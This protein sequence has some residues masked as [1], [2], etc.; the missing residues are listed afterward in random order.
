MTLNPSHPTANPP[1]PGNFCRFCHFNPG[2]IPLAIA[3]L[4]AT[5]FTASAQDTL[6]AGFANP[7]PEARSRAYW[8]WLNGNVTKAAITRDLEE[9]KAKGFGGAIIT[10]AGGAEQ[11]GNAQ[12]PA[13]PAFFSPEWRELFKFTLQEANRLGL[14]MSL[15]IQSGWNLGGPMIR[16]EDAPKKLA[17][18]ETRVH[19][20]LLFTN[21]LAEPKHAP[22]LYRDVC[23]L[24]FPVTPSA[25]PHPP[26]QNYSE[27]ALI[28]GLGW[29]TP[30]CAP[31]LKELPARPGEEDT[32]STNVL[33]ITA[34]M[35]AG[36]VLRWDAPAG[37]WLVLRLGYTLNDHSRV[38]TSSQTWQ[39]YALDPIDGDIFR[40]YW[41]QVVEPLIADAGPLAGNTFKYLHTDSWE[42]EVLNWTPS[43]RAEF[44]RRRGYD[45]L[46]FLPVLA[47][48]IVDSREASD[49]FLWDF[50]RTIGDLAIDNHFKLF[51]EG[52]HRHG[53]EIHPE[54][55]GPHSVP[56]DSLQCLGMDD[57]PMSEFWARSPIHRIAESDRFFI[58]QPAS[59][60]HTYGR[61][62]VVGEGFTDIGLHWQET[63]WDNL[64]PTFDRA[65]CE[66]LNRLVWHA[67][68]CSPAAM[69]L[70]GQQY[71]AGTHI[72]PNT[73][74]WPVA[75]PFLTYLN[76]CQFL[77][78]RGQFVA[79]A[80]QYYGNGVPNFTQLK[81]ANTAKVLPGF[82]YDVAT[83][84]VLLT[85]MAARDGRIVLPDGMS[86]RL[87]VLPDYDH[88][89]LPA[90]RKIKSLVNDGATVI[91]PRPVAATSL[92]NYPQC[93]VE[94]AAL[95]RELW[96]ETNLGRDGSPSR[97]AALA[98][99]HLGETNSAAI[100]VHSFGKGC[101]IWGKTARQVL[102]DDGIQPDFEFSGATPG[103][104]LDYI[105]RRDGYNEIYFV[106]NPTNHWENV[107]CSFRDFA[108]DPELWL[109]DTG[110]IRSAIFEGKDGRAVVPV[111]LEPYGSV[112]V[113]FRP[114]AIV[115]GIPPLPAVVKATKD[116]ESVFITSS[117][118]DFSGVVQACQLPNTQSIFQTG[119]S[120]LYELTDQTG[121]I[122]R[123]TIAPLPAP[124]TLADGWTL[125]AP[126]HEL[127]SL[128]TQPMPLPA[129]KSWTEFD[130]PKLK[131]FSGTLQYTREIDLDTNRLAA[132]LRLWL[133]LGEVHELA[134]V[135]LN[136]QNLGI[137][138]KPPW[139]VDLT[140]AARPGKNTVVVRVTN[141]WPNRIIGDQS[142]PAAQRVTQT[143]IRKLTR[144]TP[145]MA[146][147]LL[148]PVQLLTT[149]EK[150]IPF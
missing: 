106:S 111:R 79:D 113:V 67:F 91:G 124:V 82:D 92:E 103:V 16:A 126:L 127:D 39:G 29:S 119:A 41:N 129:L 12:V 74:W 48:Y 32:H 47:G 105:H 34:L 141:F 142:L 21:A 19:G 9:M 93:D 69:G 43:L 118:R 1:R 88:I 78:Q 148:G 145:L 15:N 104:A 59:A 101:V 96:G 117:A 114:P 98:R 94:V 81:R 5:C 22:E 54:S 7:P 17:W 44:Q 85:R 45:L 18:S 14:E 97:P 4:L 95:A 3:L 25:N 149:S 140:G 38:S 36:G 10:D 122:D 52:A 116:G 132:G 57:A 42:V 100:G 31:L 23:V 131:Y 109:P 107:T 46:P 123:I 6:A 146:S 53:M 50:R 64:K 112:F 37:D 51:S 62:L 27:K 56:V 84:E 26:L 133:D 2:F 137:L 60:A 40:S 89:S 138:W 147:G 75:A 8:W 86:Y 134:E 136:G 120:G 139:R 20:P 125:D 115:V 13:G 143:N 128:A 24:A 73:T 33:D 72:N 108:G 90:L 70:P 63:L 80:C 77:M 110:E 87:L 135:I 130:D 71:F 150:V 55:G 66:G 121:R 68:V 76:R 35:G 144:Q 49:R 58:K 102:L 61:P 99:E 83:E 11:E 30:D 65:L 28:Q